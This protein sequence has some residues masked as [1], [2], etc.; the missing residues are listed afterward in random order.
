MRGEVMNIGDEI[1]FIG[2]E[3]TTI[4]RIDR[5]TASGRLICGN[6]TLEPNLKIRGQQDMY[7]RIHAELATDK[8]REQMRRDKLLLSVSVFRN[9]ESLATEQLE[10]VLAIQQK[11]VK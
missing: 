11:A 2:R 3:R 5:I 1:A 9:W 6:Y 8:H 4:H 10:A 7:G